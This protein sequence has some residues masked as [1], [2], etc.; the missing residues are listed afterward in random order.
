MRILTATLMAGLLLV[1]C[2]VPSQTAPEIANHDN[3]DH[4]RGELSPPSGDGYLPAEISLAA[5]VEYYENYCF[6]EPE[7]TFGAPSC[8]VAT[9][10]MLGVI[11]DDLNSR[12]EDYAVQFYLQLVDEYR[13]LAI[14]SDQFGRPGLSIYLLCG[15]PNLEFL[16][17]IESEEAHSLINQHVEEFAGAL[18]S[19][20]ILVS[21]PRCWE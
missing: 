11:Y 15:L 20:G 13:R 17:V 3:Q 9:G 14:L 19:Q 18:I 7:E 4:E 12:D 8:G 1:G 21:L 6:I 2:A 5:I 10:G 16:S